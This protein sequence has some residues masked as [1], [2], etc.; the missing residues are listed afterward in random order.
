MNQNYCYDDRIIAAILSGDIKKI[1]AILAENPSFSEATDNAGVN[2]LMIAAIAASDTVCEHMQKRIKK[3]DAK[4]GNGVTALMYAIIYGNNQAAKFLIKRGSNVFAKNASGQTALDLAQE[5]SRTEIADIISQ[6][7]FRL[8]GKQPGEDAPVIKTAHN[9]NPA[10]FTGCF[11]SF[12]KYSFILIVLSI[13]IA[14]IFGDEPDLKDKTGT[15]KQAKNVKPANYSSQKAK[16]PPRNPQSKGSNN[17]LVAFVQSGAL[18][19]AKVMISDPATD[20]NAA[21][22]S[23][24]T[25][26]IAAA[27]HGHTDIINLLTEKKADTDIRDS[28]GNTALIYAIEA[29]YAGIVKILLEK[30]ADPNFTNSQNFSPLICVA[31]TGN[32]AI[33]KL[34]LE[35]G[36]EVNFTTP[37][38]DT[39]LTWSAY[40][41]HFELV[42]LLV[43]KGANINA[44]T[45]REDTALSLARKYGHVQLANYLEKCRVQK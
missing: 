30:G 6:R 20:I 38:Q 41:G 13:I 24:K 12:I 10:A 40:Y 27:Q 3:I 11:L 28:D 1:D 16:T 33:A 32:A 18:E 8:C 45:R 37:Y 7:I 26:L 36:A 17:L 42:K 14:G 31:K 15:P 5:Y 9:F 44:T 4:D 35:K 39:P 43:E 19:T 23:G 21:D 25:A 2:L 22:A 29:G 34:L